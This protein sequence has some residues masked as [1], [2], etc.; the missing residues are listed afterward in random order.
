MKPFLWMILILIGAVLIFLLLDY[1]V[2]RFK[3]P[4]TV[5]QSVMN[6]IYFIQLK[7]Y[8]VA[9]DLLAQ[10]EA[11]LAIT[12]EEMCDVCIQRADAHKGLAQYNQA[13][14]AYEI[15]YEA[16]Q[17]SERPIK[18]ND[19]LLSEL[20]E[21]YQKAERQEDFKKWDALFASKEETE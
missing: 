13:V 2:K 10:M 17:E 19:A 5:Q 9:L 4:Q 21:C 6:A 1:I 14:D 16:L 20:K 12:P 15:L 8:Q 3:K 7:Q 11:E 18:R